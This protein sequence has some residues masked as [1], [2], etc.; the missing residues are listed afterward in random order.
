MSDILVVC[1]A[2]QCRSPMAAALLRRHMTGAYFDADVASAG[3]SEGDQPAAFGAVRAL[4][5]RGLDLRGHK[6]QPATAELVRQASLV[7][8]LERSHVR[9]LVLIDPDSWSRTFTLKELVRRGRLVGARRSEESAEDWIERV[10]AGRRREDLIGSDPLDDVEDP[11]GASAAAF[12]RTADE[13]DGLAMQL[14]ELLAVGEEPAADEA[15]A[16]VM[17]GAS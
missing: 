3:L 11:M 7:I 5:R 2:N 16:A 10:H 12:E 15:S 17:D 9:E 6:S 1:R 13:L 14:V 4:R 8:A